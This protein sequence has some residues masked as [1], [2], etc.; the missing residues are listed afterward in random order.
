MGI[1]LYLVVKNYTEYNKQITLENYKATI[2]ILSTQWK[3]E[4]SKNID[5]NFQKKEYHTFT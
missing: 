2:N 4:Y 3:V 5:G 1:F